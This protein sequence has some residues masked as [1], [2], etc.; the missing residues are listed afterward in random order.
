[1][2]SSIT[3]RPL[4]KE[5]LERPRYPFDSPFLKELPSFGRPLSIMGPSDL[6]RIEY[7]SFK[8]R[9]PKKIYLGD[10]I[11]DDYSP[12]TVAKGGKTVPVLW[13]FDSAYNYMRGAAD[14]LG[15]RVFHEPSYPQEREPLYFESRY[16][17]AFLEAFSFADRKLRDEYYNRSFLSRLFGGVLIDQDSK[18]S[19][20]ISDGVYSILSKAKKS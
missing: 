10:G 3:V 18:E 13:G 11:V 9:E 17:D 19:Q 6:P 16:A 14:R 4:T 5:E 20:A 15:I 8:G 12:P 1:M 2:S 7:L